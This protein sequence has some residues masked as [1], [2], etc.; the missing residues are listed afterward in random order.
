MA[1]NPFQDTLS[2][3]IRVNRNVG[4]SISA[5]DLSGS[6]TKE[7]YNNE[8]DSGDLQITWD[9]KDNQ[10]IRLEK[11]YYIIAI[12]CGEYQVNSIVFKE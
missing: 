1:P 8:T 3:T 6:L 4:L 5:Y 12:Q 10:G 7:I 11:D 2:L 9:G